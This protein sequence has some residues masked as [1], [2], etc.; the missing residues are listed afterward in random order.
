MKKQINPTI[1]AHSGR[2]LVPGAGRLRIHWVAAPNAFGAAST[3][4]KPRWL[5]PAR[6]PLQNNRSALRCDTPLGR[7]STFF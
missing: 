6:L 3:E 1:K 2:M 5:Q 4:R 7:A